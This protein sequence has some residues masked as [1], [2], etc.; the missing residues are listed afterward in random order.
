M[1]NA[2]LRAAML[3]TFLLGLAS[4]LVGL[5]QAQ[6]DG[7][8]MSEM[9]VQVLYCEEDPGPVNPGGGRA[10]S[11]DT[12]RNEFDCR[13]GAG[14]ALTFS[15]QEMGWFARCD[16]DAEGECTVETPVGPEVEL[17]VAIHMATVEPGYAPEQPIGTAVNYTEFA[18][19]GVV[20]LPV[21]ETTPAPNAERQTL[22]VNVAT[23]KD[24]SNAAGC[25]RQPAGAL[26][27]ASAGEVTADGYP[28]LATN[29]EG[30]VSFDRAGLKGDTIDL[31]LQT[32]TE[33]RFACT[34]VESGKRLEAEW[35]E[36]REGNFIR[37]TPVSAGEISCD[38]TLLGEV[39]S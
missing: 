33:P 32:G 16:M 17:D 39:G 14:V 13:P 22:A 34:D 23:C 31:M 2:M 36:G 21:V 4:A 24:G 8:P 1:G 38:V 6:G 26:V 27:Q 19:Y 30:W 9:P 25:E 18:G 5:A 10:I 12:L 11:P 28:W 35:I 7:V 37:L 20:L 15:N 3:L 29:D